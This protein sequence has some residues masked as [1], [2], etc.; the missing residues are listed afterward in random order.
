MH[1]YGERKTTCIMMASVVHVTSSSRI[2][3]LQAV[4]FLLHKAYMSTCICTLSPYIG[5]CIGIGI[6][7]YAL[8]HVCLCMY[9]CMFACMYVMYNVSMINKEVCMHIQMLICTYVPIGMCVYTYSK[10]PRLSILSCP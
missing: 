2:R 6:H 5:V 1:K 7:R 10:I 4:R 8:M 3:K 9:V